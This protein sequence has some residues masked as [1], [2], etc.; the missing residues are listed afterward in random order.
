[1]VNASKSNLQLLKYSLLIY[2]MLFFFNFIYMTVMIER[3]EGIF[4]SDIL[5]WLH[6]IFVIISYGYIYIFEKRNSVS[7][8]VIIYKQWI[9]VFLMLHIIY[10][11]SVYLQSYLLIDET[12]IIIRDKILRG[13]PSLI[14]NFS[15]IN[16]TTLSYVVGLLQSVNSPLI[17][18]FMSLW[19]MRFYY[20]SSQLN[21]HEEHAKR[22]DDFLYT[23]F[24]PFLWFVL[25]IASFL[26]INLLTL[27]YNV[28]ESIEMVLSLILFML[29]L[30]NFSIS[31]KWYQTK[32]KVIKPSQMTTLH[33]YL[34]KTLLP[35]LILIL[36]L[37]LYHFL[38][39]F[40][41]YRIYSTLVALC[42]ILILSVLHFRLSRLD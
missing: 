22:Y 14:L 40:T 24:I 18:L 20:Q 5:L 29:S 11:I 41:T 38:T 13:N 17:I 6:L 9:L 7:F 42:S 34:L 37:L 26:S 31:V 4:L 15:N 33:H 2:L 28:V 10:F 21:L 19:T 30:V 25:M 1:M 39:G 27:N 12:L 35:I 16:F 8:L 23:F 32:N 3:P 36:G